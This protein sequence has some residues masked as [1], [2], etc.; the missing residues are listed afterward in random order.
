VN[1]AR[2]VGPRI[3]V[4]RLEQAGGR[5]PGQFREDEVGC[6]GHAAAL[7]RSIVRLL[8]ADNVDADPVG[9]DQEV[10]VDGDIRQY[11]A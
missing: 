10:G 3:I 9:E 8:A 6:D 7:I 5:G 4:L 1:L 2:P 11:I